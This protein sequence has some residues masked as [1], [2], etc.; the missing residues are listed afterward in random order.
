M[1]VDGGEGHAHAWAR[2]FAS[3]RMTVAGD[4]L[5]GKGDKFQTEESRR[6]IVCVRADSAAK[7][8]FRPEATVKHWVPGQTEFP[9]V[10]Q[11]LH[12]AALRSG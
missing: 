7:G 4:G 5:A 11:I 3:L 10:G 12:F 2:S 9:S 1:G 6:R 8:L